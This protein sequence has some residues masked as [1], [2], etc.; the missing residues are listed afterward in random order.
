MASLCLALDQVALAVE[1][2]AEALISV[3]ADPDRAR[4]LGERAARV[5]DS[6]R[7][8]TEATLVKIREIVG[9]VASARLSAP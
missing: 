9:A 8:A 6:N 5:L 7:G 3:L 1:P 4:E 2:L